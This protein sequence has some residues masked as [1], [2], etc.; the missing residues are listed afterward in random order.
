MTN[1]YLKAKIEER[2]S[3]AQVLENLQRTAAD[4]KR[5]LTPE[6]T[7]TF[8]GIV[9]RLT[10]LDAEIKRISDAEAG[11]AKFIEIYGAHQEAAQRAEAARQARAAQLARPEV[12]SA[13]FKSLGQRFVESRA[14]KEYRGHGASEAFIIDP[15]PDGLGESFLEE[16]AGTFAQGGAWGWGVGQNIMASTMGDD[17]EFAPVM[18]WA[19]PREPREVFP[20]WD[21]IG[22]VPTNMGSVEYFY[23]HN[24]EAMAQEVAEGELKPEAEI[25]GEIRAMPI[26]TY[27]WWKG[28]TRQALEDIPMIRGIVDTQLR[29]GVLRKLADEAAVALTSNTD[30]T[31]IGGAGD[32][33]LAAIRVGVAMVE[34]QGFSAN[35]VLMNPFD[36]AAFDVLLSLSQGVTD[37]NRMFWGLRPIAMSGLPS[38]TCYVGDFREAVTF[39]DRQQTSIFMTDSHAD[40]FLRNKLVILAEARGRVAVTNA[41]ALVKASGAVPPVQSPLGGSGGGHS[42]NHHGGGSGGGNG[43]GGGDVEAGVS[44][45]VRTGPAPAPRDRRRGE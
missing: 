34:D 28:I 4:A 32:D 3:Q 38:G 17:G 44:A 41:A 9:A 15:G 24:T 10:H 43:N 21:A 30:F 8:D 35:A 33:L 12:R 27:A 16:R 31:E 29:R 7:A 42:G 1:V 11:S 19:G 36:W 22:R 23:W 20:L 18:Q 25:S 14:F 39:F 2:T 13:A 5:D 37:L 26:S 45:P 40:Y 6:E